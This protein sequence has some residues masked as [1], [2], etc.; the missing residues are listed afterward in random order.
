M[1]SVLDSSIDLYTDY[2]PELNYPYTEKAGSESPVYL[3]METTVLSK[4]P[5]TDP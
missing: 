4:T 2:H 5:E 1:K 3:K